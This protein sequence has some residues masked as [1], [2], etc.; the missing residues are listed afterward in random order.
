[1]GA[2]GYDF[3]G[4]GAVAGIGTGAIAGGFVG[5]RALAAL[6]E[7]SHW[8]REGMPSLSRGS[9]IALIITLVMALIGLALILGSSM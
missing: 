1:M 3:I 4:W 5:Y 8:R 9:K 7:N 2:T 6:S